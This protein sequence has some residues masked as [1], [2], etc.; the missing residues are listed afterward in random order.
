VPD[1]HVKK[2]VRQRTPDK[3]DRPSAISLHVHPSL[4]NKLLQNSAFVILRELVT[5]LAGVAGQAE[6]SVDFL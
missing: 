2:T 5:N 6:E 4:N 3:P 1:R